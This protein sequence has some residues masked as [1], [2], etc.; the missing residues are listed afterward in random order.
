MFVSGANRENNNGWANVFRQLD[1]RFSGGPRWNDVYLVWKPGKTAEAEALGG[2]ANN[3]T[4]E[5]E[6]ELSSAEV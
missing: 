5:D 2:V 3:T 4:S 6:I 1:E